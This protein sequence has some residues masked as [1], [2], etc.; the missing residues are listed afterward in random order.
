MKT[1]KKLDQAL[2]FVEEWILV[3]TGTAVMMMILVNAAC[4]FLKLDWFGSEELTMFV[5][6]WLY[7]TGSACASREKTHISADMLTLFTQNKRILSTAA[8]IKNVISLGICALFTGWCFH[9]V[10]WQGG[11]GATSAVYKLPLILATI[12]MLVSF[13]LWTLYLIR[14]TVGS[15]EDLTGS[16][17]ITDGENT[18]IQTEEKE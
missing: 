16:E 14:D 7:F 8:L 4:R 5:A 18:S 15:I 9:Y 13:I 10:V 17:Q 3:I 1:F 11:L 6:F 2:L 12:P